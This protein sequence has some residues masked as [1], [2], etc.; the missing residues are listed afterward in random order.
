[1][2]ACYVG[3][4][5]YRF[6][7][8]FPN[9]Q[10]FRTDYIFIFHSHIFCISSVCWPFSSNL[11]FPFSPIFVE[12]EQ[13]SKYILVLHNQLLV[14]GMIPHWTLANNAA[15]QVF[16]VAYSTDRQICTI[17]KG[18]EP[19]LTCDMKLYYSFC[20][21]HFCIVLKERL[22]V[23]VQWIISQVIVMS[24]MST[25]NYCGMFFVCCWKGLLGTVYFL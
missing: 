21:I 19:K 18:R 17:L 13:Q 25:R 9:S 8:F 20:V 5:T 22:I 23:M 10:F 1:M 24:A 16:L 14:R 3:L 12:Q 15:S 7:G 6:T 4:S 11:V 2:M